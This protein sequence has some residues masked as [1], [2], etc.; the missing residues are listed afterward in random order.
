MLVYFS[1]RL[2]GGFKEPRQTRLAGRSALSIR[3]FKGLYMLLNAS[4]DANG[5]FLGADVLCHKVVVRVVIVLAGHDLTLIVLVIVRVI[6]E[7]CEGPYLVGRV[8]LWTL[9]CSTW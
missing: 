3:R 6:I 7:V 4:K 8:P 1:S 5:T 9:R 2:H